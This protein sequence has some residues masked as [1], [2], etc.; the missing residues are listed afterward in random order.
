MRGVKGTGTPKKKTKVEGQ[1]ATETRVR[2]LGSVAKFELLRTEVHKAFYD[3][4]YA[5]EFGDTS[6]L[7]TE[8]IIKSLSWIAD[9]CST[10]ATKLKSL[11]KQEA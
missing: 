11:Q 6:G 7:D 9:K 1:E 4:E 8:K 3:I 5:L 2:P 10:T